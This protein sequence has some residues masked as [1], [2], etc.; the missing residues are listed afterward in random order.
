[1]DLLGRHRVADAAARPENRA[2]EAAILALRSLVAECAAAHVDDFGVGGANVLEVD[3]EF[4]AWP[5]QVVRQENISRPGDL[6]EQLLPFQQ[7]QVD[8]DAALAAVRMLDARVAQRVERDATDIDEASLR[9]AAKR[10]LDLDNVRAPVGEERAGG[11]NE[12]K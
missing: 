2:V 9:I 8:T 6:V 5:R 1:V 12:H 11:R 4:P 3:V 7:R 10:M